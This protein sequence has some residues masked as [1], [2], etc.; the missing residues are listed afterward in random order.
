M[1][2]AMLNKNLLKAAEF[3]RRLDVVNR[4]LSGYNTEDV[5]RYLDDLVPAPDSKTP[6]IAYLVS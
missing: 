2:F 1:S 5:L 3:I 4:G 6:Q